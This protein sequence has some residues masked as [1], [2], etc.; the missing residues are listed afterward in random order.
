[1]GLTLESEQRME[2]A[3]VLGF[4][5]QTHAAWLE[6][7]RDTKN[8]VEGNFPAGA[9]IRR[10]DVAKALV[11]VVEV[12]EAYQDFRN[13]RKLRGKFWNTLFADLIVDRTWEQLEAEADDGED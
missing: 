2:N 13:E 11:T 9:R 8:F 6:T 10:D 12:N 7:V 1:M 3:G 5:N 4:F